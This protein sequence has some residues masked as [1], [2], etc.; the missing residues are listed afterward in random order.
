MKF[1]NCFLS[2]DKLTGVRYVPDF[3]DFKGIGNWSVPQN[4]L[5]KSSLLYCRA[6]VH[7]VPNIFGRPT[8]YLTDTK[9]TAQT[10]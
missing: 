4:K 2:L 3:G 1:E 7:D 5:S 9:S 6:F 8:P 10:P